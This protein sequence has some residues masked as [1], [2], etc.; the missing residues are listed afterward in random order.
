MWLETLKLMKKNSGKTNKHISEESGVPLGTVNKLFAGQTKD[1]KIDTLSAIVHCL[2][3]TLD[4]LYPVS[5]KQE[6]P[7]SEEPEA[8]DHVT[9]EESNALLVSLG[10]IKPGEDL[11]D[12]DLEFLSG[13][14]K[15]LDAWFDERG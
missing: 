14:I 2:G 9:L 1:P 15:L 8:G 7:A 4:D 11:S 10:Y 3:Y 12:R 6:T 5:Q 13:I